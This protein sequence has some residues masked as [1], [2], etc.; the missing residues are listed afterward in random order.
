VKAS[1]IKSRKQL[2]ITMM[3]AGLTTAEFASLIDYVV[4]LKE[5]K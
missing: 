2:G 5:K 4:S 1:E 3:P